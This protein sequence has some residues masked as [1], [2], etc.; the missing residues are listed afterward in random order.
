MVSA[1][2]PCPHLFSVFLILALGCGADAPSASPPCEQPDRD[3]GLEVDGVDERDDGLARDSQHETGQA[4][5]V[6]L[7]QFELSYGTVQGQLIATYDHTTWWTDPT[8]EFTYALF[9]PEHFEAYYADDRSIRLVSSLDV[10]SMSSELSASPHPESYR[11]LL[12]RE[13]I[14]I[15]R[16]PVDGVAEVF[17][18]HTSYH[19][20][21]DGYGNFAW[22]LV[23]TDADGQRFTGDGDN[24][25]DFLIW[26]TDV[27]LPTSGTVIEIIR[28]EP[29]N[30][31]IG[32]YEIG[33]PNNLLGLHLVGSYYLYLL[34]F[35]QGSIPED[36]EISDY[37]DAG[38]FVGRVGNSGVSAEPH[39]HITV[40][41]Y[42]A[43]SDPPRS[44]SV[45]SEFEDLYVAPSPMGPVSHQEYFVPVSRMWISSEPF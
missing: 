33:Q 3:V 23:S 27:F 41:Y 32:Q 26:G 20:D 11:D 31:V 30:T 29:D 18:G 45:P 21:E 19:L 42:D 12:R 38:T 4:E 37:L 14:T 8:G 10:V 24:V 22:D 7:T 15:E 16:V 17:T 25:E 1:K 28:D 9:D 13:G 34:H 44:W 43:T 35:Q 39:L 36:I 40:L 6:V 5:P 2:S